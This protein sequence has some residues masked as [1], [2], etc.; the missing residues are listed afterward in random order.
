MQY[1]KFNDHFIIRID[2][3][4]EI[5]ETLTKFCK[6]HSVKLGKITGVGATNKIKIGLFETAPKKYHASELTGDFEIC[7]LTGNISTMDKE[8]Y[9]H[10]H[11]TIA[12]KNHNSFGGHLTSAYVSA[13]FEVI[14]E[15][16]DGEID[17]KF[18]EE[19][20]LNLIYFR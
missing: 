14:L 4:E 18:S 2:K 17:R 3:G 12:D 13:T 6:Q 19:I 16:I 7:S 20:G 5:V 15:K 8:P 1:Q 11:C 10:L 9:L